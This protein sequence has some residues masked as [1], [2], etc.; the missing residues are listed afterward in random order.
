MFLMWI[1]FH[2]A[3][4]YGVYLVEYVHFITCADI[5]T[6]LRACP[7]ILQCRCIL[8]RIYLLRKLGLE[9]ADHVFS[10]LYFSKFSYKMLSGN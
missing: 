3:P 9:S 2:K 4:G 6:K 7:S 1:L 8:R 10:A 5:Q